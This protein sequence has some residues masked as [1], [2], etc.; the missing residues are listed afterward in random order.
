VSAALI[1]H[2]GAEGNAVRPHRCSY[3]LFLLCATTAIALH[4]QTFTTLHSFDGTDGKVPE[5]GLVQ[6]TNG[7]LYGTTGSGGANGHGTVFKISPS[8]T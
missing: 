3:A 5:A 1:F 4:G 7:N 8:G 6:A 2:Q